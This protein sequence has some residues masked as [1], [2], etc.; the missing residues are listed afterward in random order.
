MTAHVTGP[1]AAD[2]T[3]TTDVPFTEHKRKG[4][5]RGMAS[6]WEELEKLTKEEL[7]IEL[8]RMRHLYG[9][10]REDMHPDN[11]LIPYM[12]RKHSVVDGEDVEG[13]PT[14]D[15]WA[16]RIALYGAMR[17]KDGMFY[18]CDLMDYG[19]TE[20]QADKACDRLYA[21]GRLRMPDGVRFYIPGESE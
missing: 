5:E 10:L 3:K 21:E 13:E 8:V 4:G 20:D 19:L 2:E 7:I 15:E 14:T 16:E 18:S 11:P 9:M 1:P 12:E 17:P 6:E